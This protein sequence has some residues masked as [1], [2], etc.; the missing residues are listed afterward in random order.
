MQRL[1]LHAGNSLH[2]AVSEKPCVAIVRICGDAF[3]LLPLYYTM[4]AECIVRYC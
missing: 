1:Q 3:I 2:N 4:K